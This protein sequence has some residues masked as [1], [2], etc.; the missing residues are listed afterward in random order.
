MLGTSA[1]LTDIGD[2][3]RQVFVTVRATNIL[4]SAFPEQY[5]SCVNFPPPVCRLAICY[6]MD[7]KGEGGGAWVLVQLLLLVDPC[8]GVMR[9]CKLSYNISLS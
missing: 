4:L 1:T 2:V 3:T 9:K 8:E 7:M 6:M 5:N